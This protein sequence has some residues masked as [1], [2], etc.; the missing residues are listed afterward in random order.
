[1]PRYDFVCPNGHELL[2]H[3]KSIHEPHP[4][5]PECGEST[6]TLWLGTA[7]GVSA[8]SFTGGITIR[9][10][11]HKPL[12]FDTKTELKRYC[13]EPGWVNADEPPKPY[14]VHWSG[15]RKDKKLEEQ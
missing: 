8:D 3:I 6:E 12:R 11:S 13:N 1:M 7:P 9:H 14:R 10:L 15:I 4:S 2:D 5:C